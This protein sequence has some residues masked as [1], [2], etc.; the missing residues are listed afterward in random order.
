MA[1][2]KR[3]ADHNR[4]NFGF[5]PYYKPTLERSRKRMIM[6]LLGEKYDHA[7]AFENRIEAISSFEEMQE[8]IDAENDY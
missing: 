4:S 5:Q 1:E 2:N 7:I 8:K 6:D 3:R